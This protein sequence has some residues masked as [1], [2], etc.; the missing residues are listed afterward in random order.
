MSRGEHEHAPFEALFRDCASKAPPDSRDGKFD[1]NHETKTPNVRNGL[2]ATSCGKGPQTPHELLTPCVDILQKLLLLEDVQSRESRST[3]DSVATIRA[4]HAANLLFA[5]QIAPGYNHGERVARGNALGR[6]QDVR[7]HLMMLNC[8]HFSCAAESALNLVGDKQ[9]F[10]FVAPGSQGLHEA[11]WGNHVATLTQ[12]WFDQDSSDFGC[13]RLLHQKKI[14]GLKRSLLRDSRMLIG[15]LSVGSSSRQGAGPL[16][17][18]GCTGS[19]HSQ[20]SGGAAVVPTEKCYDG[21]LAGSMASQSQ[22]AL[23][24]FST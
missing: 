10:V 14:Q 1:G 18:I 21:V 19:R 24:R 9:H 6:D 22:S 12:N 11:R 5:G 4:A 8:E 15:V 13:F 2:L 7:N 20:S 17:S 16:P 3:C 23:V